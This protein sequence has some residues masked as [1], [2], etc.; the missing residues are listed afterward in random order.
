M[1]LVADLRLPVVRQIPEVVEGRQEAG[2]ANLER[3]LGHYCRDLIP[4]PLALNPKWMVVKMMVP[5]WV[6]P[7]IRTI[8]YLG[9]FW[10]PLFVEAPKYIR[11]PIKNPVKNQGFLNQVPTLPEPMRECSMEGPDPAKAL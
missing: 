4:I 5:F 8:F 7:T 1:R 11:I 3:A 2:R 6:V 9:L 10:G